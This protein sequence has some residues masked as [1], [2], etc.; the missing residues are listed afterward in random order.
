M[1]NVPVIVNSLTRR[2]GSVNAVS[3]ISFD[4]QPGRVTGL[5]GLNG[6][7]KTTT[8][9]VLLGL[10]KPTS[11]VG[12][13][14]GHPYA[15]LRNS[16]RRVGVSMDGLGSVPGATVMQDLRIW[17]RYLRLPRQRCEE[18]LGLV[19]LD[20]PDRRVAQ[21]SMGMLQRHNLAIALLADPEL[22]MLDEPVNG[23]DPDGIRWLRHT[24]RDLAA[25]GRTVLLSSHQLAEVE[26]TVDDVIIMQQNIRYVGSLDDLTYGGTARLEQRFFEIVG[27]QPS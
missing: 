9:K 1:S 25:E 2:F 6:A 4:V 5:L 20:V 19:K 24:L 11:G 21:L 7:G 15:R 22:L 27:G 18:V 14:F 12:L 23:L 8:L 17:A 13:I 26:Q 3:D 16:S 10:I